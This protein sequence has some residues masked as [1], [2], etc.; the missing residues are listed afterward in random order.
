MYDDC[1]VVIACNINFNR[2]LLK[3]AKED[4][5][6]IATDVHVLGDISARI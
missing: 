2:D 3:K 6:L 1:D 4:G 5:K